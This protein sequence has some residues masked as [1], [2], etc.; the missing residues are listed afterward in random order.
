M[1]GISPHSCDRRIKF[2]SERLTSPETRA[3][4]QRII[5]SG[6]EFGENV[7]SFSQIHQ[8][9][10]ATEYGK[11]LKAG[12]RYG[13]FKPVDVSNEEWER[14]LG[15]DAN[16]LEHL[17][18]TL[19]LTQRF[20]AGNPADHFTD[21]EEELLQLTAIVHDWGEAE[22]GDINY[23]LKTKSDEEREMVALKKVMLDVLGPS[24]EMVY[25]QIRLILINPDQGIG[26]AFNAV[27]RM[28]YVSTGI[29]AWEAAKNVDGVLKQKLLYLGQKVVTQHLVKLFEYSRSYPSVL[30]FL[31]GEKRVIDGI[32]ADA[33]E[34]LPQRKEA[35]FK[36]AKKTWSEF[37]TIPIFARA[38]QG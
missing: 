18:E 13:L 30:S 31:V 26:P 14:H 5:P 12:I 4:L 6:F 38:S 35:W 17:Y 15:P 25:G 33:T 3:V 34:N 10:S 16:N 21:Y 24:S 28:G 22:V 32:V 36:D 23:D 7:L 20:L 2:V 9:F 1:Y 8:N 37:G 11:K 29:K 27:E 19:L